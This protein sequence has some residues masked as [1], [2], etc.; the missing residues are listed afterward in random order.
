MFYELPKNVKIIYSVI[1][2]YQGIFEI[3]KTELIDIS[4][5]YVD[6]FAFI[7]QDPK[8]L[9]FNILSRLESRDDNVIQFAAP[10]NLLLLHSY[11]K[12]DIERELFIPE[13]DHK[14]LYFWIIKDTPYLLIITS[15]DGK[16]DYDIKIHLI[17]S[18]TKQH[19][20]EIDFKRCMVHDD[21]LRMEIVINDNNESLACYNKLFQLNGKVYFAVDKTF[22]STNF[23]NEI[24]IIHE[25]DEH[26]YELFILNAN[27]FAF[28]LD[29]NIVLLNIDEISIQIQQIK[30]PTNDFFLDPQNRHDLSIRLLIFQ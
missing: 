11:K 18:K 6:Q 3:L 15:T 17:N 20:G 2:E 19:L 8:T 5:I 22:F 1:N 25:F 23:Q 13:V 26:I 28:I 29:Q 4:Q 10:S 21:L 14:I 7:E 30:F 16:Y 12:K 24:S 9:I 27:I